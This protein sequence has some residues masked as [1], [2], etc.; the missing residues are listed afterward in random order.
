MFADNRFGYL[1]Q[2]R[3]VLG[4][5]TTPIYW[6]ADTPTRISFWIDDV[7]VSRSDL[8]EENENLR[9]Q[10]LLSQRQLQLLESLALENSRLRALQ[11]SAQVIEGAVLPA[12]II[13]TSPDPYSK[14]ILINKGA[15]DGVFVGQA[16]LDA[17]GLM[18]QV[19][20]VLP[21]TSWVLLITDFH[22]VTPIEVNRNGERAL[23]RGSRSG[24][25]ELE[26][27][28][29]T[30]TQDIAAGDLLVSSGMGQVYPKDYPVAEVISVYQDPGQAYMQV[31]ARPMAQIDSTRNVMLVF[32]DAQAQPADSVAPQD[33]FEDPV[34]QAEASVAEN[35][36]AETAAPQ[37]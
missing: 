26:L 25:S 35:A 17:N 4:Y 14:R 34:Q 3:F 33:L 13:N 16:L 8:I 21:F 28:F 27:E 7:L 23:A 6:V 24:A 29:V 36:V 37:E 22:H 10:L 11:D 9:E 1:D 15:S 31:K 20:E 32:A 2:V 12:E 30:Q 5:V 18:G 19:D